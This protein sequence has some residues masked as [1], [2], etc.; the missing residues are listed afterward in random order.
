MILI[1]LHY[2]SQSTDKRVTYYWM[3]QF[4]PM[5]YLN[6]C[7]IL[8]S[9]GLT[10]SVAAQ[11]V[12]V[13]VQPGS[14]DPSAGL[15]VDFPDK[16][17]LGPRLTTVQ[18]NGIQSP[19]LGLM[20]YNLDSDCFEG[21]TSNGWRPLACACSG[22]PSFQITSPLSA[23]V[24]G[25]GFP[26]SIAAQSATQ[27]LSYSWQIQGGTPSSSLLAQDTVTFSQI[28]TYTVVVTASDSASCTTTD[29]VTVSV[30]PC[31]PGLPLATITGPQTVVQLA[32]STFQGPA[33]MQYS[34]SFQGGT[35]AQS[36]V[37]NPQVSWASTG[38]FM[39][40]LTVTDPQN[41]CSTTDSMQVQVVSFTCRNFTNASA[42][43]RFGPSQAQV[44]SAYSGTSLQG[45]VV[46][47]GG[48]QDWVVPY[49]ATYRI[50][51]WGA[52]GGSASSSGGLGARM[53][54][55]FLLQAGDVL[56]V[57]VG[58]QG[59][60]GGDQGG[61]GGGTFVWVSSQTQVPLIAAGGGGG[62]SLNNGIAGDA[63]SSGTSPNNALITGGTNGQPGNATP[64]QA[65]G[66]SSGS[67]AMIGGSG[68]GWLGDGLPTSIN[69]CSGTYQN[70]QSPLNGGRGGAPSSTSG[71]N[72]GFGGGGSGNGSCSTS[73]G[74][75]GGG[76]SG[77]AASSCL[78]QLSN[79][80]STTNCDRGGGGGGSYNSGANP[81][82]SSGV[83]TGH[84]AV[85][86]CIAP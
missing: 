33:G 39:V 15:E 27:N 85:T 20:I 53:R 64:P 79:G 23:A 69:V 82:N 83:R 78:A 45:E 54:G 43:G 47:N 36:T 12:K 84:G 50:E 86:I 41:G 65:N 56:R 81:S 4:E 6:G 11:G 5:K 19:S 1:I 42:T 59:V 7:S 61:G 63:G 2:N 52:Q 34:W 9:F 51:V 77:G 46:V 75:G 68:S 76:Y 10:F 14:P 74:G 71:R 35:P 48:I 26:L 3:S 62:G 16:G 18:R 32:Q 21:Y 55:D 73:G 67:G 28:G 72:G 17:F 80:S 38:T 13:G 57:L 49:T 60:N 25:V 24:I 40:F 37:A 22:F 44:N 58:Q 66:S 8:L 30:L 31:S 70:S 29:S